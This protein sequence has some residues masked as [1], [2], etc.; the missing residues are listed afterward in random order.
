MKLTKGELVLLAFL[1]GRLYQLMIEADIAD[2]AVGREE[3][4]TLVD[5]LTEANRTA[6]E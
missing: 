6:E 3:I 4:G 1:I 5:K 2:F